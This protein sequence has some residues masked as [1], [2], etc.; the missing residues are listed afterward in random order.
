MGVTVMNANRHFQL[1]GQ[2]NLLAEHFMLYL[3]GGGVP[4]IIQSDFTDSD[5][6]FM[7]AQ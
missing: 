2:A 6:L 3:F 5:D 7:A 1:P 4:V